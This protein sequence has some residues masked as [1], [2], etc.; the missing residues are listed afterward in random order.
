[1]RVSHVHVKDVSASLA[2]ALLG[3]DTGIAVSTC[4]LGGGVN[5]ENILL[6]VCFLVLSDF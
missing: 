1:M 4:S 2:A 5:A 3:K 6:F